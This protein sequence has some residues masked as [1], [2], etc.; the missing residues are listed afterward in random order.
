[1]TSIPLIKTHPHPCSYLSGEAAQSHFVNPAFPMTA[2]IYAKL[3]EHGFRRS[4]DNVYKPYCSHCTSCIASRLAVSEF[5]PNRSQKRCQKNN[6]N[7][8]ATIKAP[9]FEQAHYD[10]YLRYQLTRHSDGDMV[11]GSPEEYLS[12]LNCS[13]CDTC[14][15][16]FSIN[17]Q[18]AAIAVVD[19][20]DNAL[21]A[22]Y[23]F[24]DP[25]FAN[26][27][28]GTY[29][30]LWQIQ[31]AI[32]EQREFVYLGFWIENCQKMAYKSHF[33]PM[34]LLVKDQWL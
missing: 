26:R 14:F 33:Q 5:K 34:Q 22:V 19:R 28:L 7:T 13:W 23:T 17:Q 1:V 21:S 24:F 30:V 31:Q 4:G 27:S 25:Q 9:V 11:N 8:Q 12:F 32:V 2:A 20:L 6:H 15:V 10:L 18:L 3:I 16:E 29:A